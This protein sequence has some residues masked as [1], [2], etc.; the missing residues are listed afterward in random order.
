MRKKFFLISQVFYPDEVSTAGLFTQLC[1]RMAELDIDV[2]VWCAQPSYN[3]NRRQPRNRVY[4]GI[5][6]R[7]LPSTYF[8]K[9]SFIG[10]LLNYLTFTISLIFKFLFSRNKSTVFSSTNPPY[11]GYI[12]ACL[13]RIK[14]R[15]FVYLIQDVFP[16]GLVR[17]GK[18]SKK[19]IVVKIWDRLNN[20]TLKQSDKIIVL[21][22]DMKDWLI[23]FY[24]QTETKMQIIPIWQDEKLIHPVPFSQSMFVKGNRLE[25]KFVI[26]YSGNMGLWNDMVFFAEAI[27][28]FKDPEILFTFIGD[29]IR[30][31]EMVKTWNKIIPDHVQL[32]TFQP[33]F[34]LND[35]LAACHVA[36]VS[37]REGAEGM[38]LPSKIMG[39]L[40]S[41]RPTIAVVPKESEISFILNE[42]NCGIQVDP[43]DMNAF[44]KALE[45]LKSNSSLREE[46]GI[47]A[48]RAFENKYSV[49]IVAEKY[50]DLI[51]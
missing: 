36:L 34:G 37:L 33:M 1:E 38:A 41:G 13:C 9:S 25:N 39:I 49:R 20:Y 24:E 47:N 40:A 22:R 6:I 23:S 8:R 12:I 3:K 11:L 27:S 15:K 21:G 30:K 32:Y 2:E 26:Q 19:S 4:K 43:G 45:L 7:Y 42:E 50:M 14:K 28:R 35:V 10:R 18:L 51:D 31:K 29:G 16:E 48:R 46:M 17:I 5:H 44:I